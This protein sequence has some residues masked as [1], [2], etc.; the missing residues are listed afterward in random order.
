[1]HGYDATRGAVRPQRT[2][3]SGSSGID[4]QGHDVR[5]GAAAGEAGATDTMGK[6]VEPSVANTAFVRALVLLATLSAAGYGATAL[7]QAP[8][9]VVHL[10]ASG[11]WLGVNVWTTFFAGVLSHGTVAISE[12]LS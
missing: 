8:A 9:A 10:A 12:P 7:P 5:A 6:V 4:I 1:M 3:E 11:I 2:V